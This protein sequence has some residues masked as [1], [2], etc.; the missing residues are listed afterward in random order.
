M[1]KLNE[2]T[3]K[4]G[5]AEMLRGYAFRATEAINANIEAALLALEEGQLLPVSNLQMNLAGEETQIKVFTVVLNQG[6][7][8]PEGT[9]WT[10][11]LAPPRMNFYYDNHRGERAWR[12]V[13]RPRLYYGMTDH[14][15]E[16][17]W[18]IEAWCVDRMAVRTFS[19]A[20]I[21]ALVASAHD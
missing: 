17:Q 9:D 14:Y 4:G 3:E 8:P 11:H 7:P 13:V 2:L 12:T 1:N 16:P 15:P 19:V 6:E 21:S 10:I 20:K 5:A 18:L